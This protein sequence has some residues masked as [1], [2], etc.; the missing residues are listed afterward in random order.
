MEPTQDQATNTAGH[1]SAAL[2]MLVPGTLIVYLGFN[3]GGFFPNTPAFVA[4]VLLAALALR[5]ALVKA[6]FE[7]VSIPLALC[8][9]ALALYALWVL[10]SG[11]WGT[12]ARALI[13][14]DRVLLYLI[15]LVLFGTVARSTFR[16]RW[17]L[18]GLTAGT[19]VVCVIGLVTRLLPHAW[20]TTPSVSNDRLSYP[21]TYWNALGLLAAIGIILCFHLASG[22]REPRV[23]RVLGAAAVPPLASTLI[24]TFSRGA[25]AAG[26]V[27]LLI[28]IVVARSRAL[29]SGLLAT[30]PVTA[31][32]LV[33]ALN[34]DA[35]AT[36][37]PTTPGAIAQGHDVALAVALC[38][39]GAAILRLL[40]LQ[41]DERL[42]SVRVPPRLRRPLLGSTLSASVIAVV[43]LT[44]ALDAP[45]YVSRQYDRFVHVSG[46]G[47][48]GDVR[49]RLINP[50][51][52]GR[53]D[54]WHV[55][56]E[57]FRHARVKGHGAG[58]YQVLW[59]RDRPARD[60]DLDIIDAHS[61]YVEVFGELGL[62]GFSLLVL[63]LGTILIGLAV[64][65]RGPNRALYGALFAAAIAW[66]LHAGVDWDW[67]MPV[68][69]AWVFAVGGAI[70]A[71]SHRRE[72]L[73]PS[74]SILPRVAVSAGLLALAIVPVLVLVS[75]VQ[76][77]DGVRAFKRGDCTKAVDAAHSSISTLGVRPEPYQTLGYCYARR[78]FGKRAIEAMERAVER[79]PDN[80]KYRYGLAL[81]RAASGLDPRPAAAEAFRLD[82]LDQLSQDAVRRFRTSDPRQWKRRVLTAGMPEEPPFSFAG[83]DSANRRV[84]A[85][86]GARR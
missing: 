50:A 49:K 18:R 39:A 1:V 16:L 68:V 73:L 6:P 32:A 65:I 41:V 33:V 54:E 86:G 81:V 85:L 38:T 71:R 51:N 82:P 11:S 84:A 17:L 21:V 13:E 78:G 4:V 14:F 12:H 66:A 77:T 2:L 46:L 20:P 55:A 59:A 75:Q 48:G 36:E 58:T 30:G 5:V 61:L 35:L 64:R 63:A 76:L 67:E 56:L 72:P 29:L 27:G 8:A 34:A 23:A 7:G 60:A 10:L 45:G 24:F 70:L 9:V 43:V 37:D 25:I 79:D 80:W 40:L 57:G 31:I 69:T 28:Y 3:A 74:P 52:N 42:E 62:V 44:L 26:I 15:V 47:A 83:I 19:V 22:K 53:I